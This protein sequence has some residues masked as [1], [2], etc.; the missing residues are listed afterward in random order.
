M[1]FSYTITKKVIAGDRIW[2]YGT[3]A[4]TGGSTGGEVNTG[5]STVE[6]MLLTPKGTAVSASMPVVNETLPLAGSA[7]GA[8]T[9]V[10]LAND[11]GYWL[12]VGTP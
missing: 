12:A 8:M 10:T 7:N 4:N 9:I 6:S 1:A 3:W 2:V 11:E 5:L